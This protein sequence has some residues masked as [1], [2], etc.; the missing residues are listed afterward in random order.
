M[1]NKTKIIS[2]FLVL[3]LLF[4]SL[5]GCTAKD[6]T[7]NGKS[8]DIV[9]LYTNDIHTHIDKPLSYDVVA[10]IKKD[11]STQYNHVLLADAGDHL[12]GTAYGSMDSGKNITAL[13]NAT[14]Y[15]TATLG[16]HDFDYGMDN[17]LNAINT[18]KFTYVSSNFHKVE[19][20]VKKDSVLKSFITFDCGKEKIA[21][22]GITTPESI[23]QTTPAYFQDN[24]GNY[25]YGISG[26]HDGSALYADVQ[27]AIDD[28]KA[29]GATKILGLGHLGSEWVPPAWTSTAVIA[30]THGFDAFIDAHSHSVIKGQNVSDKD[31]HSVILTQTGEYFN[32]IGIMIIN[33]KTGEIK[34][35]LIECKEILADDGKTVT[36]YQL[37]SELYKGT[38]LISDTDVKALKDKWIS[39]ID[40]QL[41]QKIGFTEVTFDNYEN[42]LR[43]VR[44]QETN[45]GDFAADALYYLF[46]NMDMDVDVA[47]SNG[48][49]IRNK[50][51][52]GELTYKNCKEIH[53]YGNIAC[54]Q[55]VSG[56]QLLDALEW[57]TRGV[58]T[59][60]EIGAFLQVSGITYKLDTSSSSTV[61]GNDKKQWTG[62]PTGKYR[63]YDI[64]V[65][66]KGTHK[67][68]PLDLKATYNLAGYNYFLRDLGDGFT[69][70]KDSKPVLDYVMEDYMVLANYI[71]SF[72]N[73]TIMAKNSPLLQKYPSMLLDYG[74]VNGSGRIEIH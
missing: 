69:M 10:A 5:A 71:K 41:G 1:K 19:G 68:E 32:A 62:P 12:Q 33:S 50:A 54:L 16:N 39:E 28:A 66:N 29:N 57:S 45:S 64:M 43:L 9:I 2:L 51:L 74:T 36:G 46:D 21:F 61:Q 42:N 3:V 13:M 8:D 11:L 26:G 48:G 60:E 15:D 31:G 38:E 63:V 70:F 55:T 30:N 6:T 53:T 72:E 22:V 4:S 27:K 20:G 47:I 7:A 44:S 23:T 67:Y 25:I 14:G 65:Y 56:Q 59:N 18:A 73:G 52:T 34:T 24:N 17:L 40:K 58:G 35:D 49:G 37:S